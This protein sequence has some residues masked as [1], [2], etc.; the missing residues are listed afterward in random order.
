MICCHLMA[1]MWQLSLKY[2]LHLYGDRC[3]IYCVLHCLLSEFCFSVLSGFI[4]EWILIAAFVGWD[5]FPLRDTC[6]C[7]S[8]MSTETGGCHS[9]SVVWKLYS[10][11][12]KGSISDSKLYDLFI[13]DFQFTIGIPLRNEL[14]V[15]LTPYIDLI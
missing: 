5:F 3:F 6:S 9:H 11:L 2:L 8:K 15:H 13:K 14:H 1:M 10:G 12:F 7:V 4:L